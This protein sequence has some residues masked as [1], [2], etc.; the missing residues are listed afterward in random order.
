MLKLVSAVWIAFAV[1]ACGHQEEAA[2][3]EEEQAAEHEATAPAHEDTPPLDPDNI[4]SIALKS[5]D[6]HKRVAAL[7]AA[8]YVTGVANPG[9]LTVF[10]PT[11]AAFDALPAGTVEHLLQPA[12][13][14]QLR[15]ILQHHVVPAVYL[16][17]ALHDGQ[18]LGMVDGTN[19]TVHVTDGHV[20]IGEA[21]VV[22]SIRAS[23]GI[24][25]VIDKVLVPAAH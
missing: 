19:E 3:P 11:D 15:H 8:D 12:N 10:A 14:D 5:P 25:H 4:V 2:A 6:H 24:I 7:R 22:A 13:V 18:T 16:A 1:G 21:N 17:D 23:N 9:P 20:K